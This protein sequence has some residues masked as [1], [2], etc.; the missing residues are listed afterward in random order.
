VTENIHLK[1]MNGEHTAPVADKRAKKKQLLGSAAFVM[2][3]LVAMAAV[4]SSE[5]NKK[6]GPTNIVDEEFQS[7]NFRPPSFA[8]GSEKPEPAPTEP[9][10]IELPVAEPVEEKPDTTTFQVPPP[11][12]P[13]VAVVAEPPA[14]LAEPEVPYVFPERF[15]SKLI[16]VD[17]ARGGAS[18]G[19]GEGG[20]A[21]GSAVA[22]EDQNSKYLAAASAA[23]DRSAKATKI[24][25]IDAVVP[26]GTLI[27][28]ILETAIVSDLPGQIRAVTSQDVYSF[29][30]RRVLIPTGTRLIGEYQSSIT[31][32]QKR[33]FVV[34]TRLIRDDGIAV[35]LNSIG[36]DSLGR[37]GLTGLVD[38]KWRER[39]GSAIMLSIVGAGAS[40]AT[41]YGSS[42]ATNGVTS[43]G[44]RGE[45]LARQTIA[46]TF[47]DMA[48]T[49][50][51]ENL[52]IPPTISVS[53]G[54]RIFIFVRQDLD[55]SEFYDDPVTEAMK[56]IS[57]ER[58][59]R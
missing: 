11:P 39:F 5:N 28:G 54:E 10:I 22:G 8:M 24:D 15:K 56:E 58:R 26:E 23:G 19:F 45:E 18:G 59:I 50:L 53:Q 21:S 20:A 2:V 47:S 13:P 34:W 46:Q 25:R 12:P 55:F 37:S 31:R 33:I 32:G 9:A 27:P 30:G 29:D 6:V 35:R 40:Y 42:G 1:A 43:D 57:R 17:Q 16:A 52:R 48:N 41:G 38:N 4:M 44:Q 36:T 7:M 51:Q 3:G 14:E 49:A